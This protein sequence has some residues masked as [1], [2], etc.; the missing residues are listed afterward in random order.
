MIQLHRFTGWQALYFELTKTTVGYRGRF[1]IREEPP[2]DVAFV[3]TE[4]GA[5]ETDR[6]TR[7]KD[8]NSPF[9]FSGLTADGTIVTS[10]DSQLVGKPMIID[11]MGT[12]CHNCLDAAPLLQEAFRKFEDDGL[13]VVSLAFEVPDDAVDGIK[14]IEMFKQRFGITYPVLYCGSL[15]EENITARLRIQLDNFFSYPTTIFVD[16]NGL[17]SEIHTGFNGPGTGERWDE[18]VAEFNE[19]VLRII[20]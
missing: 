9:L 13:Q 2:Q 10:E 16:R 18:Q 14:N 11:I 20:N 6:V 8:P 7:M 12:W 3:R 15:D 4:E 17:V 1:Q 5:R 19:A